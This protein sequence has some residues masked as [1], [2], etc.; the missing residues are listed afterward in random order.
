MALHRLFTMS[1]L[2]KMPT[3]YTSTSMHH[4][5]GD[6]QDTPGQFKGTV[7]A[8]KR[9]KCLPCVWNICVQTCLFV[10]HQRLMESPY[11]SPSLLHFKRTHVVLDN[12]FSGRLH[13]TLEFVNTISQSARGIVK[14]WHR[15]SSQFKHA[16][17][18][19]TT[20]IET[21]PQ[22]VTNGLK[23]HEIL[24]NFGVFLIA[25]WTWSNQGSCF[26]AF[27]PQQRE[28]EMSLFF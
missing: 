19:L 20:T 12:F 2:N 23:N 15:A 18:L 26:P 5:R 7:C 27:S 14:A 11:F 4:V 25:F 13:N 16:A 3:T 22:I 10:S 1:M 21:R 28:L 17:V 24:N 8:P 6:V 9:G